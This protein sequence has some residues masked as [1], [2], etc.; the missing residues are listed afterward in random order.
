MDLSQ[1]STNEL[2]KELKRRNAQR[3]VYCPT[4]KRWLT[5][6][7]ASRSWREELHCG[8]CRKPIENCRCSR[9]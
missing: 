5:Y 3:Q 4:C 6:M 8:G 9:I 2:K 1:A 7:G